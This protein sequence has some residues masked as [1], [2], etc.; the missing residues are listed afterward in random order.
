MARTIEI[1]IRI[2][3][4]YGSAIAWSYML[5]HA[6]PSTTIFRVLSEP[7]MRRSS[8]PRC[9]AAEIYRI[10]N[11]HARVTNRRPQRPAHAASVG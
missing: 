2:D 3:N 8:D 6:I 4:E 1:G 9:L 5:R 10:F 11:Q 7:D